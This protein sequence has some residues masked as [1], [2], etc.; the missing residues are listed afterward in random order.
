MPDSIADSLFERLVLLRHAPDRV[1]LLGAGTGSDYRHLRKRYPSA[2][3]VCA[4]ASYERLAIVARGRRFWQTA[5]SMICF[6]AAN[7][8]PFADNSFDLIIANLVLPWIYPADQFASEMNR[9]LA[10]GGGF[11]LSS[12]GPDTLVELRKAWAA[13]DAADHLNA[14][15]DMH[16]VGDLLLG[17]GVADPVV[18]VDRL[19]V[20][21]S[22]VDRLL[23]EL[24]G[25]GYVCALAGRRKGLYGSNIRD[26]LLEQ[27]QRQAGQPDG[28]V[29]LSLELVFAHGWK[30]QP[31]APS[32]GRTYPLRD[33]TG[34]QRGA[35]V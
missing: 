34:R 7:G 5:R 19:A 10:T 13:I 31:R 24:C 23:D 1:L 4:D 22:S 14:M 17:A 21:F 32:D 8:Y 28:S 15:P 35:G 33:L 2:Q 30:G 12:A 29:Q 25:L 20:R 27:L 11:F 6:D 16:D 3:I 9:V 18:D 26:R